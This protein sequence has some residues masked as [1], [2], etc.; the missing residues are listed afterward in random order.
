MASRK[1]N[2]SAGRSSGSRREFSALR[3]R[4]P[5]T[6]AAHAAYGLVPTGTKNYL[7]NHTTAIFLIDR[8]GKLRQYFKFD[9][10]PET[11]AAVLGTVLAEKP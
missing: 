8:Q 11:L 4:R 2:L 7:V 3:H 1:K 5:Q 6:R 10:E 9:E